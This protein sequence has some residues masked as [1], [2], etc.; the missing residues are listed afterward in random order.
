VAL[1]AK[2][3][4]RPF[5]PPFLSPPSGSFSDALSTH[6]WSRDRRKKGEAFIGGEVVGGVTNGDDAVVLRENFVGVCDGVGAWSTRKGG[7]AG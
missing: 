3:S 5:P 2:R 4:P 6:Q 1:F 7:H